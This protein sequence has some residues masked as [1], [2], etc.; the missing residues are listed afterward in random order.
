MLAPGGVLVDLRPRTCR[1]QVVIVADALQTSAGEIDDDAG[2][3][4]D[5]IADA[6][7]TAAVDRGDFRLRSTKRFSFSYYWDSVSGMQEFLVERWNDFA[8]V[9]D[10]VVTEAERLLARAP[11]GAQVRI[12]TDMMLS[13]YEAI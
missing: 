6:A 8:I 10:E 2:N 7:V 5:L 12:R 4:D 13:I 1:P 3:E 11:Q 9:S